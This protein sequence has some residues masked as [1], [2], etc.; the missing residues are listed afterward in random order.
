MILLQTEPTLPA[1]VEQVKAQVIACLGAM[2]ATQVFTERAE[3]SDFLDGVCDEVESLIGQRGL[4][5]VQLFYRDQW[6]V[7]EVAKR[8]LPGADVTTWRQ[9]ACWQTLGAQLPAL[10]TVAG[11]IEPDY[12]RK[13]GLRS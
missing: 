11:R 2:H 8:L 12:M 6:A 4:R 10:K 7:D 13:L 1:P 5:R 9:P 3:L